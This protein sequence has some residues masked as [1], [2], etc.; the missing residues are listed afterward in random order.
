[1]QHTSVTPLQ[2]CLWLSPG[3]PGR[4]IT[5][6]TGISIWRNARHVAGDKGQHGTVATRSGNQRI[7]CC[8]R[9]LWRMP[10]VW[11]EAGGSVSLQTLSNRRGWFDA[12]SLAEDAKLHTDSGSGAE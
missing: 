10:T 2:V 11:E 12:T 6:K 3:T 1:M 9:L 5:R 8:V 7:A 4:P